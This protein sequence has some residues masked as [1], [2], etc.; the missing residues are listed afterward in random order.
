MIKHARRFALVALCLATLST[1]THAQRD[2]STFDFYARGPYRD[3]V[4][5][6]QTVT[7]FDV[8]KFH[9]NYATMERWLDRVAQ[10]AS[11]R[12][13]VTDIGETNEHRMMHVVVVTA[14]ENL[15]RIDEIKANIKRLSDPRGLSSDEAQRLVQSTPLVVWLAYTIHG[16]ESASFEAMMQVVYQ[17]A[18]S[19]EPATLDILKNTV[20]AVV[21]CENP[22]GHERFVTWYNSVA[23]GDANPL[24]SEHREPWSVYGRLNH[25]RFDLNRDNLVA[26]QVENRNMQRAYLDWNPQVSVDHHGQPSQF[27]FPPAA[28]PVNPN[29]PSAPTARWLAEFGRANSAQ[30]DQRNWD[31]YVRDVYDLFYPGYWDSW[32][33]LNG[34]TGMTYETDGGGTKGYNWRRDDDTIVTLRSGIAKHFIASLTTLEVA[35]RNRTARLQD[36]YEF[37]RSATE[38]GASE[39]LK[40][41]VIVPGRDPVRAA[42]LVDALVRAGIA[43]NVARESFN[44]Q[45][46][47]AYFGATNA[48]PRSFPAGSYIVDLAQPQKRLAKA[49]LEQN[50]PQDDAFVREQLARFARNQR[51]GE[52]ASKEDY[53]F[54]DM[55]AWSLPLAYGVEAYWTEDAGAVSTTPIV[56]RNASRANSTLDSSAMVEGAFSPFVPPGVNVGGVNGRASVAYLIPYERNGAAS[57]A[58]RLMREG[59]KLAV[60]QRT[61]SA[62]G[63]TWT[64]GTLVVRVSRN[65]ET[66]HE[67]IAQLARETGVEVFAVNSGFAESGDTVIGSEAVVSLKRPRI[68]VVADEPVSQTGYGWM[69]WTFDRYGVD[70]TPM[71]I[72]NLKRANLDEYNV[73]IMPDGSAGGYS[74]ALGKPGIDTLRAWV[75][76]G[77]TLVCV[78]G[79]AVFAALKEVNLTSSRLV[80]SADDDQRAAKSEDDDDDAS[81][82]KASSSPS[83]SATPTPSPSP[84]ESVQEQKVASRRGRRQQTQTATEQQREVQDKTEKLE[85]APPDLPPIASPSAHPERVPE[86]VP[87]AVFLATVDRSTPLTYGYEDTKLPVL[88]DSAYFFRPS[89]EGTNAVVFTTERGQPLRVAGFVWPGNT[90]RLLRNTAYVI[91]EPTGRGHVVLFA[92]DPNYR[93][94]WR[95]TTRLFFNSFLFTSIF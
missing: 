3:S 49:L 91:D 67:R 71:T 63:R 44:S 24:A 56:S 7:H 84:Q 68:I 74:A 81:A 40:R 37:H 22:D 8:G 77:G 58:Y 15:R 89:K 80:G 62:G 25:Y 92:E 4:P 83:P 73:I 35:A 12:V 61:L 31:Y 32:P 78:K 46:A 87:G 10:A 14:P 95:A 1:I 20:V 18:A 45:S 16:N 33:A 86:A 2:D 23:M 94:I 75:Q 29:L 17:L 6:P 30:F 82:A 47:H 48:A 21:P 55:T 76:R 79:A 41:F 85:G 72:S 65:P 39:P 59:F 52:G 57:L 69:W 13:R 27:F 34:A 42:E 54:Y 93:G 5:R 51:R 11:D 66:L 38:E 70:F 53:G 64:R 88:I 60:A 50:T 36:Y 26:T 19:D 90:E 43:V 28:L 9:T